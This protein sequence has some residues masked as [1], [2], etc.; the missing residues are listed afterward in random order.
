MPQQGKKSL[1]FF[2]RARKV[3]PYGV[4]SNFRYS[5]DKETLV[6]ADAK[7]GYLY[8]FDGKRYIDYRLGWGP[9]ILGHA[10]PF[11]NGRVKEAIDHGVSFAATQEFEVSV[12]ER[13]IQMNPGVEM[14]RLSNTGSECT[15]HAIRLARGYTGRDLILKFEGSYHGAHD[16]VLWSTASGDIDEV[17]NRNSPRAHKQSLGIPELMRNLIQLCPWNDVEVLGDILQKRGKEIAAIIVEPILGNGNGLMPQPGY[18]E[19]LREQCD[20]HGIV[21]IFDEV[22]TGFRI[23]AGGARELF[24]VIPDISTYAKAL[25]NG[26]PVAA[27][28]G[29]KDIMMTLG[30]G[31][32]FQGG[33]YTGNVVS[34]AAAD[35]TLE[36]MQSGKVFPQINKVG[37]ILMEGIQEILNRYS[38][39]HVINGVPAM[40][41]VCLTE[42]Q[43]KDWRDLLEFCDWEMLETIHTHMIE[44]G[45]L[46]ESDGFEPYF[47]CS[48]HTEADAA[49]T[50]TAFEDGVKHALAK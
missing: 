25:G 22:K 37:T 23:A 44:N 1:A 17:G 15:M 21:L 12:A 27:I 29:G 11:V 28:G 26:Y 31:K 46:P 34:T 13:I 43:P 48:D 9:I 30:P 20:Q 6:V 3:I 19:F 35:A 39:P 4:N 36:F 32:V 8:D 18:L 24:N 47:L 49:E 10:D 45:I 5:G 16:Y 42:K 41:G 40:F 14:V 2:E 50:L 33:T 7:D 38:I